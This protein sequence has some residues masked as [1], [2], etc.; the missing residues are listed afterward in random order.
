MSTDMWHTVFSL[1]DDSILFEPFVAKELA[2]WA[3]EEDK[4]DSD[5][6]LKLLKKKCLDELLKSKLRMAFN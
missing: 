6:Y 3:V 2:P 5:E 4:N 1:A